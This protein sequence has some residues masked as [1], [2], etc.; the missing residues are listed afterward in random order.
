MVPDDVGREVAGELGAWNQLVDETVRLT[1]GTDDEFLLV[2][3][4]GNLP[5]L[6]SAEARGG[7]CGECGECGDK[8]LVSLDAIRR[9]E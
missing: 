4:K 3:S 7:E 2:K 9:L 6:L 8:Y 5:P 1:S